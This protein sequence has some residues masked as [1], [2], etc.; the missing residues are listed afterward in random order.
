[1]SSGW[2]DFK[3][4][5]TREPRPDRS[6]VGITFIDV[7][8]ALVV[9]KVLEP[10]VA[11][12]K[13]SIVA[14]GHLIVAFM[15]TVLSWIGYHNSWNRPRYFISFANF[16]LLQF[17]VDASLVIV[18]W[19]AALQVEG[20]FDTPQGTITRMNSAQPEAYLV[21][22]S[23]LLYTAWDWI[24]G[25]MRADPRYRIFV[26]DPE[27]T[28]R[29]NVTIVCCALAVGFALLMWFIDPQSDK[30]ILMVD[31]VLVALL[32][33]YRFAKEGVTKERARERSLEDDLEDAIELVE[34]A[35]RK[36]RER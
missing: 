5:F 20:V 33:G 6:L 17:L 4:R 7:L 21:A 18:Y 14:Y 2:S 35:M 29:R 24:V 3:S 22:V 1:L 25:V 11:W 28:K 27:A 15:L 31:G 23:F 19:L 34:K 8:F 12:E 26:H 36:A 9:G 10:L 16:P 32:I 30:G 13:V